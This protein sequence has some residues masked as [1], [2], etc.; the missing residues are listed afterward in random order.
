MDAFIH[1]VLTLSAT[2]DNV[3]D[4]SLSVTI[5]FRPS[6]VIVDAS[7]AGKTDCETVLEIQELLP[8]AASH[9]MDLGAAV[10]AVA[11]LAPQMR[12]Q[13][14]QPSLKVFGQPG[15]ADFAD[16]ADWLSAPLERLAASDQV[17]TSTIAVSS[18]L[19]R[20]RLH[21]HSGIC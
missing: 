20:P 4:P 1:K 17:Q 12:S 5:L 19:R 6:R 13:E 11:H 7:V 10:L 3:K 9:V 21:I 18:V 2:L 8:L 16:P 14:F 15:A